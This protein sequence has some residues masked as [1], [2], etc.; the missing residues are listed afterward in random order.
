MAD[1]IGME[2]PDPT[3][4]LRDWN[5]DQTYSAGRTTIQT[6]CAAVV[7]WVLAKGWIDQS[8]GAMLAIVVPVILVYLYTTWL[9]LNRQSDKAV[10]QRA[11]ETPSVQGVVVMDEK[12][13]ESIPDPRVATS[14]F[15]PVGN[16]SYQ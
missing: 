14:L 2:P 13:A 16:R 8:T 1:E 3:P 11:A 9:G 10:L 5:P 15:T 4:P 12:V 7:T 6:I